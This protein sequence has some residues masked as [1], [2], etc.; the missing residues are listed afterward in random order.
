MRLFL[1]YRRDDTA[2]RAGRLFDGL[3]QRLGPGRVFQDV[4]AIAPGL[5][6]ERAVADSLESADASVVVIGP[7]WATVTAPGG[8]RRLERDDDFVRLEVGVAL[9]SERPVVPVLVGGAEMPRPED[10]PD[11]LRPLLKRQAFTVRDS[12]WNDD[13]DDLV[14]ALRSQ[15]P[16]PDRRRRRPLAVAAVV[17]L[18]AVAGA[19]AAVLLSPDADDPSGDGATPPATDGPGAT[20]QEGAVPPCTVFDR[21]TVTTLELAPPTSVVL[22]LADGSGRLVAYTGAG[23][24]A[25]ERED[26][27]RVLADVEVVNETTSAPGTENYWVGPGDFHGI[28]VDGASG[29]PAVDCF[30]V[31]TGAQSLAPGATVVVQVGFDTPGDPRESELVLVTNGPPVPL[32]GG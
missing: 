19:V 10:L 2:G 14:R 27:W 8:G 23:V 28:T 1:S 26:A 6:F 13:V 31:V 24:A 4:E 7:E 12:A 29:D 30:N 15:L 25:Q 11:E 5:D 21:D 16:D 17:V 3:T 9:R 32:S 22:T 18:V 20:V